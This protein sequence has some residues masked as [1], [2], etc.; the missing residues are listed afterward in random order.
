MKNYITTRQDILGDTVT[1][2]AKVVFVK[3]TEKDVKDKNYPCLNFRFFARIKIIFIVISLNFN[4]QTAIYYMIV[5][6]LFILDP[7]RSKIRK[8]KGS[9]QLHNRI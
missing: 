3:K 8:K 7:N 6:H 1:M 4:S 5:Y 2:V 9:K